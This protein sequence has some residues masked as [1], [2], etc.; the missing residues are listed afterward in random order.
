LSRKS[1]DTVEVERFLKRSANT[2][3]SLSEALKPS[4]TI[5]DARSKP[6]RAIIET[7][8]KR[9]ISNYLFEAFK[10]LLTIDDVVKPGAS[11]IETFI[12]A[13]I[14]WN[15]KA[16]DA[17]YHTVLAHSEIIKRDTPQRRVQIT[18]KSVYQA[19]R[20]VRR[21]MSNSSKEVGSDP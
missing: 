15:S 13:K 12:A 21:E 9:I 11:I 16:F 6:G 4:L 18:R 3:N 19:L 8:G 10:P 5:S 1:K 2:N 7:F 14:T 17:L 20:R